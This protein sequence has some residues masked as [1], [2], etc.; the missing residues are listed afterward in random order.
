MIFRPLAYDAK[1]A[2]KALCLTEAEFRGL[3]RDG[4]L[5]PGVMLGKEERWLISDLEAV[6]SGSTIDQDFET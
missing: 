6:L 3:V 2:A 5:P 1:K 4:A